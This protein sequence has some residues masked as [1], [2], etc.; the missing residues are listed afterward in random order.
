MINAVCSNGGTLYES[1][2]NPFHFLRILTWP[3]NSQSVTN[4]GCGLSVSAAFSCL[5]CGSWKTLCSGLW[6]QCS[7]V[8]FISLAKECVIQEKLNTCWHLWVWLCDPTRTCGK[9]DDYIWPTP[10]H[11]PCSIAW[12][13][14][15]FTKLQKKRNRLW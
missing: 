15:V 5:P 4:G 14:L 13:W 11:P 8:L 2:Y 7:V 1:S 3:E 9:A 12:F 10:H 6:K